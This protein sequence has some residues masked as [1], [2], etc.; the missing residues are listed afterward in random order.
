MKVSNAVGMAIGMIVKGNPGGDL[1]AFISSDNFIMDGHHRWIASF[2]VD[3][4]SKA[5]GKKV[6]LPGKQLVAVLNAITAGKLGNT[7]NKGSGSF[8]DFKNKD[9]IKAEID[10]VVE[11]GV[12]K[13][14]K[15]G[16]P[17][18]F[19]TTPEDAKKAVDEKGGSDK[20]AD[21][22]IKNLSGATLS[23]PDW[24]VERIQMPVVNP[25]ENTN[26]VTKAL[27]GGEVD[28][29][30]PYASADSD[31][32]DDDEKKAENA[33]RVRSGALVAERWQKLAGIIKG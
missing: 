7:G 24:A 29:N 17:A 19:F 3:P 32:S 26:T 4:S 18:G 8:A 16:N 21:E 10:T 23:T 31:D 2:M 20:L 28:L 12:P 22:F 25:G 27:T 9:K 13:F 1:S 15:E 30:P 11:K 14:D 6:A 5:G 33:G